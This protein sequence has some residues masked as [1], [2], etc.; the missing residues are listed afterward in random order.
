MIFLICIYKYRNPSI[1]SKT[2]LVPTNKHSNQV[3][4]TLIENEFKPRFIDLKK[5]VHYDT[6]IQAEDIF[7][8]FNCVTMYRKQTCCLECIINDLFCY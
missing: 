2:V 7:N 3:V 1:D 8:G 4:C 5:A 6:W